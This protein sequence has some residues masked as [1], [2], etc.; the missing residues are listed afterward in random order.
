MA[1]IRTVTTLRRKRE[2]IRGTF[3]AYEE[4]GSGKGRSG[5][6]ERGNR[7]LRGKW[8]GGIYLDTDR[9]F[10][11][12]EPMAQAKAAL[13]GKGPSP[14]FS[15]ARDT[16]ALV[17][18]IM[19]AKGMDTGGQGATH[20][21]DSRLVRRATLRPRRSWLRRS[22]NPIAAGTRDTDPA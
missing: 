22:G 20:R 4:S 1:E 19:A 13:S 7:H 9:R 14:H 3:I 8:R 21:P 12:G 10:A 17:P 16:R 6:C 15:Q 11:R 18:Y 5:A 2:E